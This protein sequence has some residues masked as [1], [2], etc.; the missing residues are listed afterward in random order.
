MMRTSRDILLIVVLCALALT[1]SA[2]KRKAKCY[3]EL[4]KEDLYDLQM[5]IGDG[6]EDPCPG[7]LRPVVKADESL[8]TVNGRRVAEGNEVAPDEKGFIRPLFNELKRNRNV[9]K[10]LH[11]AFTFASEPELELSPWMPAELAATVLESTAFAGYPNGS[12]RSGNK[13]ITFRWWVPGPPLPEPRTFKFLFLHQLD[14][15]R[16]FVWRELSTS[17]ARIGEEKVATLEG[18]PDAV[19]RAC[20]TTAAPCAD[21]LAIRTRGDFNAVLLLLDSAMQAPALRGQAPRVT[22]DRPYGFE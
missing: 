8:V 3:G 15:P 17:K 1:A 16:T 20:S 21:A 10:Q 13:L 14:G 18:I 2:C 7:M 6:E 11:P 22:W 5:R 19:T 12:V 4:S 9:W